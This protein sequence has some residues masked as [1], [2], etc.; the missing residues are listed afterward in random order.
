MPFFYCI[1]FYFIPLFKALPPKLF[2]FAARTNNTYISVSYTHLWEAVGMRTGLRQEY[3]FSVSAANEKS[4]FYV[5]LGYLGNEGITE[6][7]D[8][9]RLTEMCIRDRVDRCSRICFL[10]A[11]FDHKK[12]FIIRIISQISGALLHGTAEGHAVLQ[13]TSDILSN[14]L[15]VGSRCV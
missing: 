3:N 9:K 7:S 8:L 11:D 15:S 1:C 14:Q 4:S 12:L 2:I 6:G 5:S 10:T 13:L